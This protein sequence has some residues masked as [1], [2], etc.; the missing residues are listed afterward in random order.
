V[1]HKIRAARAAS[2]WR[3]VAAPAIVLALTVLFSLAAF[4]F[5]ASS[6][7]EDKPSFV[8]EDYCSTFAFAPDGRIAIGV[9]HVFNHKKYTL[10]GDD[11]WISSPDGKR[12]R[13]IEGAKLVK[14]DK[15]QSFKIHEITWSPDGQK[16]AIF[17]TTEHLA[18]DKDTLTSGDLTELLN[19]EGGEIAIQG[20]KENPLVGGYQASWLADGATVAFL[21]EAVKPRELAEIHTVTVAT[22][23]SK[24][25]FDPHQFISVVWDA[26][27]NAAIAIERDQGMI[28]PA[29]LVSLD[30]L[31]GTR[32]EIAVLEN[33]QGQL[34]IS[35]SG[36]RVAFFYDGDVLE[37]RDLA[38]PSRMI[39]VR[40]GLGRYEWAPDE[41]HIL[42]KRGP[43]ARSGNLMWVSIPEGN[44]TPAMNDLVYRDFHFSPDG[45]YIG[46]L[47]VTRN[48]AIYPSSAFTP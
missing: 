44:F 7:V 37:V 17:K 43:E 16:L 33:A 23:E 13:I 10:E 1:T 41:K 2:L 46:L 39:H 3:V 25:L 42:L 26:P 28:G 20:A 18:N 8:M 38:A 36:K 15:P 5:P 19:L 32:K 4:P 45:H 12:K 6:V 11:L 40:V 21:T 14:T 48:L 29:K 22:G 34:S 35:P 47:R 9:Y 27:H 24:K 30:L 31:H